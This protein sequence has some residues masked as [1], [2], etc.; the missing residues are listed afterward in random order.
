MLSSFRFFLRESNIHDNNK[1]LECIA[2]ASPLLEAV[3]LTTVK[4]VTGKT[5]VSLARHCRQLRSFRAYSCDNLCNQS[6]PEDWAALGA[7]C[8]QLRGVT[9]FDTYM[10][11]DLLCAFI[12][13]CANS[14]SSKGR[15]GWSPLELLDVDS[16]EQIGTV[17]LQAIA[18]HCPR[19]LQL[20]L[21]AT[22]IDAA[23]IEESTLR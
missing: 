14:A 22:N 8:G 10:T 19:L 18:Q 16:N 15:S 5:L 9:I 21:T 3:S 2:S 23:G 1:A 4:A 11:D 12:T 20:N 7:S 13:G 6:S 17:S